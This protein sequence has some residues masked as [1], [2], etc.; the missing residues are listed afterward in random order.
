MKYRGT[1]F[2]L[3]HLRVARRVGSPT[4]GPVVCSVYRLPCLLVLS[5]SSL[6]SPAS[7][8]TH[9]SPPTVRAP[10]Y[11]LIISANVHC[12]LFSLC[13]VDANCSTSNLPP[14]PSIPSHSSLYTHPSV[15]SSV[16]NRP[17]Y[18]L[19]INYCIHHRVFVFV[20]CRAVLLEPGEEEIRGE[21]YR[22]ASLYCFCSAE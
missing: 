3:S 10:I 17:V 7:C 14:A 2:I 4:H 21:G 16:Q 18:L 12:H 1:A 19:D 22:Y 5:S 8:H 11:L 20:F 6:L 9:H 13:L 15:S